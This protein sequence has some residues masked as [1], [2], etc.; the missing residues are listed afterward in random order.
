[1]GTQGQGVD[2]GDIDLSAIERVEIVRGATA[3]DGGEGMA[4]TIRLYTRQAGGAA[5]RHLVVEAQARHQRLNPAV[6]LELAGARPPAG[7]AG[8]GPLAARRQ[9]RVQPGAFAVDQRLW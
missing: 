1:V 6:G 9:C 8:R 3:A 2:L 4:G 7:L 5:R